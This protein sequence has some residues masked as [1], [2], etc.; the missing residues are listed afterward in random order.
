MEEVELSLASEWEVL[1]VIDSSVR[2][3]LVKVDGT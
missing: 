2:S 3:P 1:S